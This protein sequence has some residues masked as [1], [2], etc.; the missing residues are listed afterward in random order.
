MIARRRLPSVPSRSVR[1]RLGLRPWPCRAGPG[2][3]AGRASGSLLGEPR[4]GLGLR[5]LL[6]GLLGLLL[7]ALT[8]SS[9]HAQRGRSTVDARV[10]LVSP[11]G[12]LGDVH[13]DAGVLAGLGF[14]YRVSDRVELRL[15][16]T[17]EHLFDGG[18]Q[19]FLGAVRGPE[20]DLWH[21]TGGL[22]IELTNPFRNWEVSLFG[23]GGVTF[24]NVSERALEVVDGRQ[25]VQGIDRD[26]LTDTKLTGNVAVFVGYQLTDVLTLFYRT[27]GYV[28]FG[29]ASDPNDYLGN[30]I[31]LINALGFRVGF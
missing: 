2:T 18:K 15:D 9:A 13:D 6:P 5:L 11:K 16:G 7:L 27:E 3:P 17:F 26:A 14:G 12:D 4:P 31:T 28:M 8:P 19:G 10:G 24:F 1:G 30:E 25:V 29:A 21:V 23:G 22:G 20:A